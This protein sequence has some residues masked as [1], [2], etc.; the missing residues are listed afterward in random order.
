MPNVT[1]EETRSAVVHLLR[2]AGFGSTAGEVDAMAALGYE[3]A[4]NAVCDFSSPDR[5]ADAVAAPVFDTAGYIASRRGDD[6]A[7]K[8]ARRRA[9]DE[10][11]ALI[12]WWVARMVAAERPLREKLTF[13]W[14]DHFATSL[15]KVKLAELLFRQYQTMYELG[16]GRF[17]HLVAAIARDPAMLIWLDG[18]ESTTEAPNENFA[19]ELFELFTLGHAA[20]G[21]GTPAYTESDIAEASRALTGWVVRRAKVESEFDPRRHDDG[22]KAVLGV[23]GNLGLDDVVAASVSQPGCAPHVVSCLWS[24]FA[25]PAGPDDPVVRELAEGFAADLDVAALLRRLFLHAEF[26]APT[27]RSALLKTPVEFVVGTA[28]ALGLPVEERTVAVLVTLGQ[29]PFAP[30]DVGGWPANEGW[31]STSS[32][33]VRLRFAVAAAA[34]A[35]LGPIADRSPA[36]RPAFVARLLGV[37]AWG[38]GTLAALDAAADDPQSLLALA[39]AAPEHLLG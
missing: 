25:R 37:D 29:V 8:A 36:E 7:R 23:S 3:G 24:R 27:T 35:D 32:A 26:L 10:R 21:H 31:V 39:I 4:V 9:A 22:P 30:P 33:L 17:D 18:R 12:A 38:G 2:R 13:V 19:R 34:Q 11:K 5:A 20:P 16:P 6:A 15:Q 14:H 1:P 28:R